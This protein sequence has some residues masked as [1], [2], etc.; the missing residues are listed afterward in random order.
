MNTSTESVVYYK[1]HEIKGDEDSYLVKGTIYEN[2]SSKRLVLLFTVKEDTE[3]ENCFS[4]LVTYITD[5]T[6]VDKIINNSIMETL[7]NA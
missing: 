3:F 7:P 5:D 4:A 2:E 1:I 6:D